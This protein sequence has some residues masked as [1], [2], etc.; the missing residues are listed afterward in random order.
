MFCPVQENQDITV[1]CFCQPL[2][3][4]DRGANPPPA[5]AQTMLRFIPVNELLV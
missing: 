1:V 4:G 3:V 2:V 5:N